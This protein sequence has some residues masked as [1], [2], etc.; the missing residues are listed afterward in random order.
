MKNRTSIIVVPQ[1]EEETEYDI[2]IDSKY[3]PK[4]QF[5][6]KSSEYGYRNIVIKVHK[7]FIKINRDL[8]WACYTTNDDNFLPIVQN[9][10]CDWFHGINCKADVWYKAPKILHFYHLFFQGPSYL[11]GINPIFD[12]DAKYPSVLDKRDE[13]KIKMMKE[14]NLKWQ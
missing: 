9:D 13:N 3:V 12:Y 2:Y 6:K 5:Y 10:Y 8:C 4:Y 1:I 11:N 7:G 14:L